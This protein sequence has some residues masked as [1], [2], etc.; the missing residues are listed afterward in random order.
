MGRYFNTEGECR[1]EVHYMV[2]F[3]DRLKRIKEEYVDKGKYFII[4][5]GMQYGKTTT[6]KALADY[7]KDTYV[8]SS[9]DFQEHGTDDFEDNE[10]DKH[11]G[12]DINGVAECIYGYTSR[13]PYLVSAI[14]KIID[15]D[16][17]GIKY[18]ECKNAAW[19]K[20]DIDI[21]VKIMLGKNNTLFDSL[22]KQ[23]D[24]YKEQ[25]DMLQEIIYQK[26]MC[27][28]ARR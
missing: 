20:A 14:C 8:I 4:N 15:E 26:K 9:M 12:M 2:R 23:I 5:R 16:M 7:L 19:S 1:P 18:S 22:T 6:L 27:R 21:A 17:L 28:L 11:T 24:M 13:Y 25:H 3:D 10:S